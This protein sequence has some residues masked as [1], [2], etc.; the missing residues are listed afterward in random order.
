MA[1]R[2]SRRAPGDLPQYSETWHVAI[3]E[4]RTWI[5]PEDESQ[6][7]GHQLIDHLVRGVDLEGRCVLDV[8]CGT[9]E[10]LVRIAARCPAPRSSAGAA[11]SSS[12]GVQPT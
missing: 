6:R 11:G 4:L 10:F 9:G 3:H 8:G 2:K 5:A 1:L 7:Y 12:G